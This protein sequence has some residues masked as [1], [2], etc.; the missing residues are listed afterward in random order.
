[1]AWTEDLSPVNHI[2]TLK[3]YPFSTKVI[4][5]VNPQQDYQ[6]Q[7]YYGA[8]QGGFI[9]WAIAS[10]L[11]GN[12]NSNAADKQRFE[13]PIKSAALK[14]NI[15]AKFREQLEIQLKTVPWLNVKSVSRKPERVLPQASELLQQTSEDALLLVE[16]AYKFIDEYKTLV[17]R[18]DVYMHPNSALLKQKLRDYQ[19][20]DETPAL[21]TNTFYYT[22]SLEEAEQ[23][24]IHASRRWG[25]NEGRLMLATLSEAVSFLVGNIVDD[26]KIL[27]A[28]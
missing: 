13:A 12:S 27:S 17:V 11:V 8:N 19:S 15:G 25:E 10:A 3:P 21:Y 4:V 16:T 20:G 22:H 9:G 24:S 2:E 26:F 1:M 18:S 6:V 14:F 5:G 23:D 7:S 28:N